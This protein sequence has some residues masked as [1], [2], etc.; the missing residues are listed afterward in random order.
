MERIKKVLFDPLFKNNPIALQIL[1]ICS[2]LAVTTRMDKALVMS[3]AVTLVAGLSCFFISLI[4]AYIPSNIRMII[5][6]AVIST[7]VIVINQFLMAFIYDVAKEIS[8][9]V[10]LIIT[11]C[12]VIGRAEGFAL[13]NK[14]VISFLD[15]VGNGLGY[16]L[17]LMVVAFIRELIGSGS[18]FSVQVL[19]LTKN[20]GWYEPNGLAVLA[21][22]AFFLI[23]FFIW[24][25]RTLRPEQVEKD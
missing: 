12:I 2:A 8:V 3:I 13:Q 16:S 10:A 14:P 7:I 18:V 23:G 1:G 9:F 25:L 24:A 21:P 19:P 20:G 22:S 5:Q 17:V 6:M 15:G 4:R 11:N